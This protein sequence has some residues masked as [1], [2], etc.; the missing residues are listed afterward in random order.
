MAQIPSI[1]SLTGPTRTSPGISLIE[2]ILQI[3]LRIGVEV[4]IRSVEATAWKEHRR[5]RHV[6]AHAL[7]YE[8]YRLTDVLV[9]IEAEIPGQNARVGVAWVGARK[10]RA[11]VVAAGV[12]CV[13]EAELEG[14]GGCCGF[15]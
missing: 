15:C 8:L 5:E 3:H 6:G 12:G 11:V 4:E 10:E 2:S 14:G 13:I 9:V 7:G 1:I